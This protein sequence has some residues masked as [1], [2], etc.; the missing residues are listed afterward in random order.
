[1]E[2]GQRPSLY[3]AGGE[4]SGQ[5]SLSN[6]NGAKRRDKPPDNG[7]IAT[8]K[9]GSAPVFLYFFPHLVQVPLR[10]PMYQSSEILR[11]KSVA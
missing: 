4:H 11:L 6:P 3:S 8:D 7:A 2:E 10:I 5:V 9:S 1:M